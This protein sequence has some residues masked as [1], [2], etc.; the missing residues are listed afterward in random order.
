MGTIL[1]IDWTRCDGRGL[2][3]ELLPAVL[4][5]DD[6]GYPVARG[7]QGRARTDVP[8]EPRDEEAAQE[9]VS[10]CPTMALALRKAASRGD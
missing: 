1:H 8:I 2:C 5:R 9:A 3:T 10:L 7:Y 4:G 6:W